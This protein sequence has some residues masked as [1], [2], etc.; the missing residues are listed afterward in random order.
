MPSMRSCLLWLGLLALLPFSPAAA[1]TVERLAWGCTLVASEGTPTN[2]TNC[3]NNWRWDYAD[4]PA[5][6][7]IAVCLPGNCT[8]YSQARWLLFAAVP[9]TATIWGCRIA[10]APGPWSDCPDE[11]FVPFA[12]IALSAVPPPPPDPVAFSVPTGL[13]LTS[14]SVG[15]LTATWNAVTT[16]VDGSAATPVEYTLLSTNGAGG[17]SAPQ[18]TV[19]LGPGLSTE[20]GSNFYCYGVMAVGV[21]VVENSALSAPEC[22]TLSAWTRPADPRCS[23]PVFT[24]A[25]REAVTVDAHVVKAWACDDS[26]GYQWNT[27]GANPALIK[28]KIDCVPDVLY[29]LMTLTSVQAAWRLCVDRPL[30]PTEEVVATDLRARWH[31]RFAVSGTTTILRRQVYT[32]NPDGSRGP[33]LVIAGVAQFVLSGVPCDGK[34][35]LTGTSRYHLVDGQISQQGSALPPNSYALCA[36]SQP[37]SGGWPQS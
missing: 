20:P 13:A 4:S 22:I 27:Y 16:R 2:D 8:S 28:D 11:G 7:L 15:T 34:S 17:S 33:Q 3:L 6:P 23:P 21:T 10:R 36:I 14:L 35:R 29:A 31:A 32:R 1:Q 5:S 19:T 26:L 30:S 9:P 37:P 12:Q 25:L 24:S 18:T